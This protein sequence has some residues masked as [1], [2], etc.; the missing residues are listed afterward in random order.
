[1]HDNVVHVY[2]REMAHVVKNHIHVPLEGTRRVGET[3]RHD[4]P[5][6]RPPL[7]MECWFVIVLLICANLIESGS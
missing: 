4:Q 2:F 7:G 3:K 5:L 6:E 1:M